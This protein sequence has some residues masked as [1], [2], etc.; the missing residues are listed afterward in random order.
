M[1]LIKKS[2]EKPLAMQNREKGELDEIQDRAVTLDIF[3]VTPNSDGEIL[4]SFTTK[5]DDKKFYFASGSLKNFIID[6]IDG[7]D[8]M[9]ALDGGYQFPVSDGTIKVTYNGKKQSKNKRMYND[10]SVTVE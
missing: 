10:W 9:V 6:N 8:E 2:I 4:V 7:N 1:A 5:E 3:S